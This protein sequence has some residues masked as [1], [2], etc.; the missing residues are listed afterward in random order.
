MQILRQLL[1]QL[2]KAYCSC[3]KAHGEHRYADLEQ[4]CV[5]RL[6]AENHYTPCELT[7]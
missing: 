5:S 2:E 6:F 4:S 1:Q 7:G 3:R